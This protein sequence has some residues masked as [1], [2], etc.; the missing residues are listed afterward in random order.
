MGA[1]S[2]CLPEVSAADVHEIAGCSIQQSEWARAYYD[3]LRNDENKSHQVAAGSLA[4][5]W[6]RLL[7][8]CWKDGKP[9]HEAIYQPSMRR[10]GSLLAGVLGP[11][12]GVEWKSVAGFQKLSENNACRISSE[13]Y[14]AWPRSRSVAPLSWEA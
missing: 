1:Y 2:H 10:R 6:L 11:S 14:R 9:Y 3:H 8:G 4:F 7:F 13:D 12:T 5:K